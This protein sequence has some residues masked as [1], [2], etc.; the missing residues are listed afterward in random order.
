VPVKRITDATRKVAQ[1]DLS[2]QLTISR[3]DELGVLAGSFNKM[4]EDLKKTTVSK[5]YVDNIIES[6]ND[7]LLVVTPDSRIKSVN[8]AACELLG[9]DEP[10]L[11]GIGM[12]LIIPNHPNI[13]GEALF[14]RLPG[15][16]VVINEETEYLTKSGEKIPVL[17][18]A[19]VMK[20]TQG[21][22][23][24]VVCIAR[25]M[26]ERK[27]AEDALRESE[28]ELHFLSAQLLTAQEKERRRLSTELHDELGQSLMVLKLKVRSIQEGLKSGQ[29]KLRAECDEGIEYIGEVIENVRRLSRD[30]SP[31]VLDNLGLSAAIRRLVDDFAKHT[32]V[33]C[34]LNLKE[35]ENP[36]SKEEE[37]TIYRMI[38]ESL[39]NVAKHAEASH[40]SITVEENDGFT[41]FC[42]EDDG[43]G[44]KVR[45]AFGKNPGR[46]GLGLSAMHERT[47]M[48][49]GSIDI[50]SQVGKGTRISF[51]IPRDHEGGR[52]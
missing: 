43:R 30:L 14:K 31:A 15:E 9:Y 16:G 24:G 35:I 25:D 8:K 18:S 51:T 20:D 50:L 4:T 5:G 36:F 22:V 3:N 52:T 37:I 1:G 13:C 39:T 40:V 11:I 38:Q 42:V 41:F 34:A 45:E 47:R 19:A 10:E 33:E 12:N 27:Q 26:T 48:L 23:E 28:K 21:E 32:K 7:T 46:K 2:A 49:G 17:F 6:M 29:Q 44:F